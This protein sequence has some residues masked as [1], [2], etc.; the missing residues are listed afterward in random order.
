MNPQQGKR[1]DWKSI[2]VPLNLDLK[3]NSKT[4]VKSVLVNTFG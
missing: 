4:D 2:I 3:I 1:K